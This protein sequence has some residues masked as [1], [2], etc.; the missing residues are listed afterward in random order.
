MYEWL[1]PIYLDAE[2][3]AQICTKFELDSEIEL[4]EFIKVSETLFGGMYSARGEFQANMMGKSAMYIINDCL[5][6]EG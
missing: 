1:N 4:Q 6:K 2:I 5:Y 3:Q